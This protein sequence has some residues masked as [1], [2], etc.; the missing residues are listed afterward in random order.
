MEIKTSMRLE[1]RDCLYALHYAYEHH[2]DDGNQEPNPPSVQEI[3]EVLPDYNN[4]IE[5]N[6]KVIEMLNKQ[7][8]DEETTPSHNCFILRKYLLRN[9]GIY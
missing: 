5:N 4:I 2:V 8:R 3:L 9:R 1:E 6:V 7:L